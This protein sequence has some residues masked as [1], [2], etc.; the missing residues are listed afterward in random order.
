MSPRKK[1]I[2]RTA[3]AQHAKRRKRGDLH[4]IPTFCQSNAI[5]ESFY[6]SLKRQGRQPREME[7][8]GRVLITPE[9]EQDWRREREAE[10]AE[11]RKARSNS[12]AETTI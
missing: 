2:R 12:N 10:T 8:D 9:A 4:T 3:F 6:F 7:V 11:K 5:S 1:V